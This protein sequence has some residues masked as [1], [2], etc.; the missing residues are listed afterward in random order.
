MIK[1]TWL[2]ISQ[3]LRKTCEGP[4]LVLL[5]QGLFALYIACAATGITFSRLTVLVL[6]AVVSIIILTPV[7]F[8]ALR[9]VSLRFFEVGVGVRETRAKLDWRVF[10]AGAVPVCAVL[11]LQLAGKYP[12]AL[13]NDT[14]GQW[15]QALTGQFNNWHPAA[16]TMLMWLTTRL[17]NSYGF[18]VTVQCVAFS[19]VAGW[20]TATLRAWGMHWLWSC[21]FVYTLLSAYSTRTMM[22]F[23]WKDTMVTILAL[24]LAV[25]LVNIVL[26]HGAWLERRG[27]Q[28]GLAAALAMMTMM[29]HNSFFFTLP[30][31]V[32][33]F[34]LFGKGRARACLFSGS[35]AAVM[36]FLVWGPIY[37]LA[38]V[39]DPQNT[40]IESV[41]LP[42]T[43]LGSVY[44]T[45]P[46]AID[47]ETK[48][49][50][51][52]VASED[53]WQKEGKFGSYETIK[54]DGGGKR[55][56]VAVPQMPPQQLLRMTWNT[57]R[58]APTVALRAVLAL[59]RPVWDFTDIDI[60]LYYYHD[61]AASQALDDKLGY[62]TISKELAAAQNS[63][64]SYY[65]GRLYGFYDK[66]VQF[67]TP[68]RALQSLG[69]WALALAV[70]AFFSLQNR[71]GLRTLLLVLPVFAY[72]MGT[73][74]LLCFPDHRF[75][76]FNVVIALPLLLALMARVKPP[77]EKQKD[78]TSPTQNA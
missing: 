55:A 57:V 2:R 23:A 29:R 30:L 71:H 66:L 41:G 50:L 70:A 67:V 13:T 35:L 26:S 59:T 56:S 14:V 40:Y 11:L 9:W 33:L 51:H 5:F 38:K 37:T 44:L 15:A 52:T 20:M 48:A 24:A 43:I 62:A 72:N 75:F 16:H 22:M 25:Q 36:I 61:T 74:L 65:A 27:N 1:Q 69:L 19:L 53:V 7:V 34:C 3:I 21:V 77:S 64:V 10:A 31:V 58:R 28:V 45:D 47:S 4:P 76:Q 73:M 63:R 60:Y 6:W 18:F 12:G 17:V 32:L 46:S 42:M 39:E 49:F 54:W 68:S 8:F 78:Q